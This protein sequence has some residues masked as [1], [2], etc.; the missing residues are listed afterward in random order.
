MKKEDKFF[1]RDEHFNSVIVDSK[2]DLTGK[3]KNV[4]ILKGNQNTFYG[5]IIS[6]QKQTHYAA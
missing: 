6:N 2:Y 3:I 1:G 4:K 5:E